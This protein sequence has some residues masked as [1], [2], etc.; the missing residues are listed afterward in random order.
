MNGDKKRVVEAEENE[1]EEES[2]L[3]TGYPKYGWIA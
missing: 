1:R 2:E 3:R